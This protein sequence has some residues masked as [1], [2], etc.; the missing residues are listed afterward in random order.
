MG[1]EEFCLVK[2]K[3]IKSQHSHL[4]LYVRGDELFVWSIP[5]KELYGFEGLGAAIFLYMEE[6]PTER[7]LESLSHYFNLASEEVLAALIRQISTIIDDTSLLT[8][9]EEQIELDRK[10]LSWEDYSCLYQ[11]NLRLN[12]ESFLLELED[13]RLNT[14]VMP[15]LG[16]LQKS[17]RTS[18][19]VITLLK[20]KKGGYEI[21]VDGILEDSVT[22]Y[23]NLLPLLYDRIRIHYYQ[24][25]PF[26]VALHAAVLTYEKSALILPGVSGAGKSTLAAYLMHHELKLF[27]DEL[28]IIDETATLTPLP[29]GVTLKEGSW[30]VIKPFVDD[31]ESI[32]AHVRFDGQKIKQIVPAKI[33]YKKSQPKK[34]VFVFPQFKQGSPTQLKALSLIKALHLFIDAGYHLKN[35]NDFQ[36]L[37]LWLKLLSE[38]KLYTLVYSNI[39]EATSR[40]KEVLL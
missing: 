11:Y 37:F 13:A 31:M 10:S 35:P 12:E 27:S 36:T 32:N 6:F 15:S 21:Y 2:L 29:L 8:T 14:L 33:E 34:F 28:T 3:Y 5:K 9:N 38:A 1:V 40:L 39:E 20:D 25:H 16:H 19:F 24:K 17:S 22:N 30:H 18:D 7:T 26:L 23:K 4:Y